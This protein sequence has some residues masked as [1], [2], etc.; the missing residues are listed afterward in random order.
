M[1][2]SV[3]PLRPST[4]PQMTMSDHAMLPVRHTYSQPLKPSHLS[5]P[6]DSAIQGVSS[7]KKK[8]QLPSK[9][10][11][12]AR[13]FRLTLPSPLKKKPLYPLKR[14]FHLTSSVPSDPTTQCSYN[15]AAPSS[16]LSP[17][18]M[19]LRRNTSL[20]PILLTS[21]TCVGLQTREIPREIDPDYYT[22]LDYKRLVAHLPSPIICQY[23][24]E[25]AVLLEQLDHIRT[26]MPDTNVYDDYTR[27]S[28]Y[29][30]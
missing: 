7:L 10:L 3:F 8:P 12:P 4:F 25:D 14:E 20:L 17:A 11:Q 21:S 23:D 19:K 5:H 29:S 22:L 28:F 18:S 26:K 16:S 27:T 13:S 2:S 1:K 30:K 6:L 15:Y 24:D 9:A